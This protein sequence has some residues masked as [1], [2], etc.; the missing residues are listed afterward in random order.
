MCT[1]AVCGFGLNFDVLYFFFLF[2]VVQMWVAFELSQTN[3][4]QAQYKFS[5]F[6]Q[7]FCSIVLL[8][9]NLY[10]LFV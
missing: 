2:G 3:S 6:F 8:C 5:I 9:V 10:V 1:V 4:D 7:Q